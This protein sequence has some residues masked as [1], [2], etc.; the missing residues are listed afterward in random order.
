[1]IGGPKLFFPLILASAA[2][3][4][5]ALLDQ[6]IGRL[7]TVPAPERAELEANLARFQELPADR[8]DAIRRLDREIEA[9]PPAERDRLLATLDRFR[10]WAEAL[11]EDRR[12]ELLAADPQR[13]MELLAADRAS[14][15]SR[16]PRVDRAWWTRSAAFNPVPL[17]EA[18]YLLKVW[19]GL[20]EG[21]RREVDRQPSLPDR[22][23]MLLELG[24]TLGIDR[25]P[26]FVAEFR[27]GLEELRNRLGPRA[28]ELRFGP[29]DLLG[30]PA[31]GNRNG[32]A[33][34]AQAAQAERVRGL[35]LRNLEARWAASAAGQIQP[36]P[37]AEL[38]A[39]EARLPAWYRES[40]DPLPPAAVRDRLSRLLDLIGRDPELLRT[41]TSSPD[42]PAAP[43]RATAPSGAAT[44]F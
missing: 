17:F 21:Q 16:A 10:N 43:P 8:R 33:A 1:M 2:V 27:D 29:E 20:N 36:A 5:S 26:A 6:G 44:S 3:P 37:P 23:A 34:Q 28:A 40:L 11:P 32:P 4:A 38:A 30:P 19:A 9:R 22:Q 31:V 12:Q 15:N 35:I 13:R 7:R 18:Y 42:T 39:F 25:D 41:L 24:R 14:A